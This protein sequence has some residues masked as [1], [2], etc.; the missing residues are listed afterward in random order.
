MKLRKKEV[1]PLKVVGGTLRYLY[2]AIIV[3]FCVFPFL[4]MLS[5]S[6]KKAQDIFASPPKFITS[7]MTLENYINA[8]EK[9]NLL[10]YA[11]NSL[12]VTISTVILTII[13]ATLASFA[14][15]Y[16]KLKGTKMLTKVLYALQMLPVVT[17]IVPLYIICG[18]MG[19]LN[20]YWSLIF[21]YLGSAVPVAAI[22]IIGF[23]TDIPNEIGEAAYIDGCNVFQM[24]W[25]VI[26]PLAVP[27]IVSGAIYTFIRIWQEF[28]I[29][30]SFTSNKLMYT[31]PIGLK[32][33]EGSNQTDWGGLMATAVVISVPAIIMFVLVQKQF[34]DSMAG[35]VKG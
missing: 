16:L 29:A 20:N 1:S 17:S 8:I 15:G 18:K 6:F 24:F 13:I 32:A 30:L 31:L 34:V 22:L 25:R 3:I 28:I 12:I 5:T 14:M 27:G 10:L 26:L 7:H 33:Y 4:W 11:K 23:F 19:L 35:S 9:N 21:T 2:S